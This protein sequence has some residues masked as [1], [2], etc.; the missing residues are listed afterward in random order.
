MEGWRK[1][2]GSKLQLIGNGNLLGGRVAEVMRKVGGSYSMN[3]MILLTKYTIRIMRNKG[4]VP[5][6]T[7]Q[8]GTMLYSTVSFY[9]AYYIKSLI[10]RRFCSSASSR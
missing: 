10:K 9:E 2:R 5:Y 8:L 7:V 4:I 6:S 1:F 3:Q